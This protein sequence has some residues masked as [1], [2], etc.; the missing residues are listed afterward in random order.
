MG[1][2]SRWCCW[3]AK[4]ETGNGG[5]GAGALG[6]GWVLEQVLRRLLNPLMLKHWIGIEGFNQKSNMG[7][8]HF[9]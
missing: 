5:N 8:L 4:W 9:R 6:R 2:G 3:E 7:K 1:T